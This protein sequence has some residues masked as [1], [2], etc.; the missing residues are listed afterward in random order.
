MLWTKHKPPIKLHGIDLKS[1]P[2]LSQH[3]RCLPI[4][5]HSTLFINWPI[6]KARPPDAHELINHM[7]VDDPAMVYQS[8]CLLLFFK[9]N[10]GES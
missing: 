5:D 6:S 1:M 10:A 9:L 2:G 4:S 7:E 3:H 8:K